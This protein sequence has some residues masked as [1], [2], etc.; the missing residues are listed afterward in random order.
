VRIPIRRLP[1]SLRILLPLLVIGVTA[2]AQTSLTERPTSSPFGT[3][4][5]L[6]E[7][8][9]RG[10][11]TGRA[12]EESTD[13]RLRDPLEVVEVGRLP[14]GAI[15]PDHYVV[16][17]GDRFL[18][19]VTGPTE[20][21]APVVVDPEGRVYLPYV[22]VVDVGGVTLTEARERIDE[23]AMKVYS[24]VTLDLVL[25][26]LRQFKVHVTGAVRRPGSYPATAVTR[27]SELV[28]MAGG[29]LEKA[30]VR[31]VELRRGDDLRFVDLAGFALGGRLERNPT[32][33]D[34]EVVRVPMRMHTVYVSGAVE[35]PGAY[36]PLPGERLSSLISALGGLAANV[37]SSAVLRSS[38]TSTT[39]TVETTF[40]YVPGGGEAHDPLLAD[41]DRFFFRERPD[42][43]RSAEVFVYGAVR[44][45]GRYPIPVDG[46]SL[47]DVVAR[48]GGATARANLAAA[49]VQRPIER[50]VAGRSVVEASD[51]VFDRQ[52]VDE[53]RADLEADSAFV[54]VDF[55]ELLAGEGPPVIVRD[56]DIVHVPEERYEVRVLGQVKAPGVYPFDPDRSVSSYIDLAGGYDKDADKGRTRMGRFAGA[57]MARAG[58]GDD[59]TSGSVIFVPTNERKSLL[60]RI[61]ETTTIVAG[62]ASLVVLVDRLTE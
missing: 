10:S 9:E 6:F 16:G 36:D 45:P 17:P 41:G 33:T 59:V 42:F 4:T 11:L 7:E 44:F 14:E 12:L 22:G 34:G 24:N 23:A 37:D 19:L 35:N 13:P 29:I 53:Q 31:R 5:E 55:R 38:F 43:L 49:H 8:T 3:G 46:A 40:A 50:F 57:P 48:A 15:D 60:E 61:R 52:L 27:V 32:V 20:V 18:F 54:A 21:E 25:T 2:S 30:S 28:E 47:R 1:I 58:G 62:V 39:E 26:A 51:E 56:G